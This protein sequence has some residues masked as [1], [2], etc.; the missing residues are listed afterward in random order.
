MSGRFATSLTV[1]LVLAG[2]ALSGCGS[3]EDA[4]R[5]DDRAGV[6]ALV[7]RLNEAIR[8]RD[9]AE[10]C[11]IFTPSSVEGTFGSLARCQKETSAVLES[12]SR[13]DTFSVADVVFVD[14]TAKV[15]FKGRAG[16]ANV[17]LENGEWYFSLDQQ[18]D[19]G[20]AESQDGGG[21]NGG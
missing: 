12:S 19:P 7:A 3:S 5:P 4:D 21:E 18:V 13:P 10:W 8:T 15:T 1:F 14:D 17:V 11:R 2:A 9:P 16:D 6:E 20:T